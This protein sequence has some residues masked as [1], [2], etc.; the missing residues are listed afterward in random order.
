MVDYVMLYL[1][2]SKAGSG[3][4]NFV[5]VTVGRKWVK[6]LYL[7][8][9]TTLKIGLREYEKAIPISISRSK[10]KALLIKFRQAAKQY[11]LSYPK[12]TLKALIKRCE[13]DKAIINKDKD[14]K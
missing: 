1:Q 11:G 5:V 4:R 10:L 14:P 2:D 13:D 7:P 8:T 6:M 3:F 9:M 12:A